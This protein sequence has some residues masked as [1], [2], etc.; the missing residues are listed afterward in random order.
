MRIELLITGDCV[1]CRKAE[2]LWREVCEEQG[3][4]LSVVDAQHREGKKVFHRMR[5]NTLPALLIDGKLVA[6]GVQS[7]DQAAEL[8]APV[9]SDHE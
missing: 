9:R 4:T 2:R 8:L 1:P 6:V 7:R 3:L 5:L